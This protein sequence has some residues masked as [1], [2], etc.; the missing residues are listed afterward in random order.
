LFLSLPL[1]FL[2]VY[3]SAATQYLQRY[4]REKFFFFNFINFSKL[5]FNKKNIILKIRNLQFFPEVRLF[6]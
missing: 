6:K 1:K 2:G 4:I 5:A 3:D